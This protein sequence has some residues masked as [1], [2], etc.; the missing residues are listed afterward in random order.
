[1]TKLTVTT[2][3]IAT[4]LISACANVAPQYGA[5]ANNF[6]KLREL[7]TSGSTRLSVAQFS[8]FEPGLRSITC[9]GVAPVEPPDGKT[10][11]AFIQEALT[12]ELKLAGIYA[13]ES[14][15]KLE[16]KLEN[17]NFN[18]SIG[19]GKWVID[20]TFSAKGIDP[21]KVNSTYHFST[22]WLGDIAC[23]QVAT[24]LPEAIQDLISQVIA[25]PDFKAL[26]KQNSA[27]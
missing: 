4:S 20:M 16:A 25:H 12:T 21:F 24:A 3:L 6:E 27:K 9:R 18:S 22:N 23:R 14:P 26:A 10:Y 15:V 8:T 19:A 5:S 1:M 17:I 13:P 7:S 2:L 11:E